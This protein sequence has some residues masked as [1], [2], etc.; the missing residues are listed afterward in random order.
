MLSNNFSITLALDTISF[1]PLILIAAISGVFLPID[2]NQDKP[3][4]TFL[5]VLLNGSADST[6]NILQ[7]L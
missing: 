4:S 7:S 1:S 3:L 5:S 6:L 2:L